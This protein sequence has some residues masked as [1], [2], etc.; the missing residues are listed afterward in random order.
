MF[1]LPTGCR[2]GDLIQVY[3]FGELG[4]ESVAAAQGLFGTSRAMT[5]VLNVSNS[6]DWSIMNF[7]TVLRPADAH[8][9]Q[10]GGCV[11]VTSFAMLSGGHC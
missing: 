9:P 6:F 7:V 11:E 1:G 10:C 4:L 8:F 3:L 2:G 5:R